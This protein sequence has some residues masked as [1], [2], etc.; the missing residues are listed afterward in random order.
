MSE[1]KDRAQATRRVDRE[2]I[3]ATLRAHE[4]ELHRRGVRHAALFGSIAHAEGR[5]TSD[6]DI[7]IELDPQIPVGLF[8]YV[9]IT[10][11]LSDLFPVRVDVANRRSLKPLVRPSIERDAIYAFQPRAARVGRHSREHRSRQ[12]VCRRSLG[13]GAQ[14]RSPNLL[15]VDPLPRN[16]LRSCAPPPPERARPPSRITLASDHGAGNVYRRD[17][18][19]VGEE[20]VW[21]TIQ[22]NLDPLLAA[23]ERELSRESGSNR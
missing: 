12:A 22:R 8:E 21:H 10:Q 14:G 15:R 7:L 17:Y 9:G 5:R 4:V 19:N 13:G 16:Y 18:D 23:V 11:Y 3:I 20:I 2:K 1:G 6:I